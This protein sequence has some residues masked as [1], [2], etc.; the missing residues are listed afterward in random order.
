MSNEV[1]LSSC[2]VLRI[3]NGVFDMH[4]FQLLLYNT[5]TK[6]HVLFASCFVSLVK[7]DSLQSLHSQALLG[8]VCY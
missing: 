8:R 7:A 5:L 2:P 6:V 3:C 1:L 4:I